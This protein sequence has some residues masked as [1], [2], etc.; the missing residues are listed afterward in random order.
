LEQ[1][2]PYFTVPVSVIV[3]VS[4]PVAVAVTA[5]FTVSGNSL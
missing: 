3:T 1:R 2:A 4:I 5:N